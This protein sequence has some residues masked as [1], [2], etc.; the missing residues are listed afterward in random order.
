MEGMMIGKRDK[1]EKREAKKKKKE[2]G[3]IHQLLEKS[4]SGNES[5][6]TAT[7]WF[8]SKYLTKD[9]TLGG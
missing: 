8:E 2:G 1:K 4:S 9:C 5:V 7:D 3:N 6:A